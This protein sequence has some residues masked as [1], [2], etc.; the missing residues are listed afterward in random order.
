[1]GGQL[2][3]LG[4]GGHVGVLVEFGFQPL[5]APEVVLE[6]GGELDGRKRGHGGFPFLNKGFF[7]PALYHKFGGLSMTQAVFGV[8]LTKKEKYAILIIPWEHGQLYMNIMV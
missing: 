2:P 4:Q 5:A 8:G 1:M 6:G 7:C 3:A